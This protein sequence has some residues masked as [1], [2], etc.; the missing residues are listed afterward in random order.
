MKKN[1]SKYVLMLV[2][3]AFLWGSTYPATKY[4]LGYFIPV[5]ILTMRFVIAS[6]ILIIIARKKVFSQPKSTYINS[7][8]TGIF[9]FMGYFLNQSGTQYTEASKQ[10][11]LTGT[12]VVIVPFILYLMD[13]RKPMKKEVFSAII[14]LL[15]IA[16]ISGLS[17]FNSVNK[18]D[19][20]TLISTM[21][22]AFYVYMVG[23][24]AGKEDPIV[25]SVVQMVVVAVA[26]AVLWMFNPV[27]LPADPKPYGMILY[28]SLGCTLL[29]IPLQNIAQRY[30]NPNISSVALSLETVFGG[31]LGIF[32]LGEPVTTNFVIGAILCFAGIIIANLPS[33]QMEIKN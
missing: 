8:K 2:L 27:S 26:S 32:V 14:S 9:L 13:K 1:N 7:L 11:F 31:I 5:Q 19:V 20:L 25:M 6:V 30:V 29:A 17:N 33:R 18:G 3:T 22:Y 10:A 24:Y 28:L 21:F 23:K 15:G 16:V 12:Y 4:A